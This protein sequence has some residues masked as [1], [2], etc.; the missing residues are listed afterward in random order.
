MPG[1][2]IPTPTP[3]PT[4]VPV[5]VIPT[6]PNP[7]P[8]TDPEPTWSIEHNP[9]L[10]QSLDLHIAHV[11]S[12]TSVYC[13]MMN[14]SPDGQKIAIGSRKH[15]ENICQRPQNGFSNLRPQGSLSQKD[16]LSIWTV[17]FS[18]DNRLLATGSSDHKIRVRLPHPTHRQLVKTRYG[19]SRKSA[20]DNYS[21]RTPATSTGSPSRPTADSSSPLHSTTPSVS[22]LSAMVPPRKRSMGATLALLRSTQA[23]DTLPLGTMIMR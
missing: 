13:I 12:Y 3:P 6:P 14:L 8:T 17:R 19:I 23:E 7:P 1:I 5:P 18:P 11:L 9:K 22:G 4:T 2:P 21:K 20:S 10:K 16:N 15:R